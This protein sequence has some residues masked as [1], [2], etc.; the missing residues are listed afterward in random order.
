MLTKREPSRPTHFEVLPDRRSTNRELLDGP[1]RRTVAK[2]NS[3]MESIR[4]RPDSS[5]SNSEPS[6]R[7]EQRLHD[8]VLGSSRWGYQ[9]GYWGRW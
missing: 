3:E 2:K 4:Q 9:L 1:P 8:F 7:L 5:T 6:A